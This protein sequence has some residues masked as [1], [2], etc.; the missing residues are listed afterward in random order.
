MKVRSILILSVV[1]F[2][3]S[4]SSQLNAQFGIGLTS[5]WDMYNRYVNPDDGLA[6]GGNGSAILNLGLGPKI[7]VGGEAFSF[8]VE[9][10]ANI[11]L[12]GLSL[13]EYKGLGAFSVPI[14]AKLNFGGLSGLNKDLAFGFTVGAGIQYSK[15][16]ILYLKDSYKD[17]GVTRDY[18]RTINIQA[19]YGI[20]ISGFTAH[21]FVR[22][23]FNSDLEGAS[24][25]HIGIQTDFNFVNLKKIRRP[26]SEL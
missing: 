26:E 19:G 8:S 5:S 15:T 10:Q 18:Y 17:L 20:G 3:L 22:Y 25:L 21:G 24:N 9:S 1:S 12:L 11:G 13:K 7:W 23:G 6:N 2:I 4:S 14:M 16:E